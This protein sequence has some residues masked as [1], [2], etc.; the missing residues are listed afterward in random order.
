DGQ[1]V[2]ADADGHLPRVRAVRALVVGPVLRVA[3]VGVAV[4]RRHRLPPVPGRAG[5]RGVPR[6]RTHHRRAGQVD[7]RLP[8][9]R[10]P[11]PGDRTLMKR[12]L[13]T[14]LV[15]CGLLAGSAQAAPPP[16][17][18]PGTLTVGVSMPS[19][20]FQVG[21]VDGS[22]VIYAQGLEIDLANELSGRLELMST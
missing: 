5:V 11:G 1:A 18:V 10:R 16:T 9:R 20:G 2:D 8:R 6:V 15:A 17:M 3:A 7:V 22:R 12:L 19:E 21:V 13:A 4:Q 14:T